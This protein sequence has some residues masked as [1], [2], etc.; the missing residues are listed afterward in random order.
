[1]MT[2]QYIPVFIALAWALYI[3]GNLVYKTFKGKSAGCGACG[4][5][6]ID[7]EAEVKPKL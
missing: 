3:L 1:M 2:W 7:K 4:N 6:A 5:C